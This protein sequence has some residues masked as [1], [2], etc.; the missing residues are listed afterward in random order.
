MP[1]RAAVGVEPGKTK[2][3]AGDMARRQWWQVALVTTLGKHPRKERD[4]VR[5]LPG[6]PCFSPG[7]SHLGP[8]RPPAF[9]RPGKIAV[10]GWGPHLV[11]MESWALPRVLQRACIQRCAVCSKPR[12]PRP[13]PGLETPPLPHLT[14]SSR[15]MIKGGVNFHCMITDIFP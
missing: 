9:W 11:R 3:C 13:L 15:R 5:S 12:W 4:E 14:G 1:C 7:R 2:V 6:T 8:E 10:L